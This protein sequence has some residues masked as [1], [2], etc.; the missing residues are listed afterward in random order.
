MAR[1]VML[2]TWEIIGNKWQHIGQVGDKVYMNGALVD[3]KPPWELSESGEIVPAGGL[4][5]CVCEKCLG[6]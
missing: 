2:D 1:T 4:G 5:R 3:V 6:G